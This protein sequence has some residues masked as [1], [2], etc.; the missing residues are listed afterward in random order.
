MKYPNIMSVFVIIPAYNEG[1]SIGKVI[2][3]VKRYTSNI[4]IIDDG[5]SD[6][7]YN[8]SKEKGVVVLRHI[9]NMGKGSALKTGCEFAVKKGAEQL[10]FIDADGQHEAEEI[11]N[12]IEALKDTDIVFGYRRLYEKM[13]FV[14]KLGN[15]FI[16]K[17]IKF[18]YNLELKDTQCGYRA[19]NADIYEKIKW[20]ALNYSVESE[21]IAN[22]GKNHL[23]YKE[24]PVKTIYSSKYKGTTV[25]DGLKIVINMF[26]WKIRI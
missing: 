4:I 23:R 19:F 26:L 25:I 10:I 22:V 15:W 14:L 7:T 6:D 21:I 12:F 2:E 17:S 20:R 11:P 1:K 8:V 3:G 18:L 16:N 13:P 5:S 24:I 9:V